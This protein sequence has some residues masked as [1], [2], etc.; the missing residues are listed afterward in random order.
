MIFSNLR[1]IQLQSSNCYFIRVVLVFSASVKKKLLK[2]TQ[3]EVTTR[4]TFRKTAAVRNILNS[5]SP[6][7]RF[8]LSTKK[9]CQCKKIRTRGNAR[10]LIIGR[11]IAGKMKV[12][13][14]KLMKGRMPKIVNNIVKKCKI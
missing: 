6:V 14:L 4:R 1:T 11:E 8:H 2:A 3:I 12:D 13:A 7:V 9:K 5:A 10:Y